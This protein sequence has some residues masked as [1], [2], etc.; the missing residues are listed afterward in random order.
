[1]DLTREVILAGAPGKR[2]PRTHLPRRW[3]AR[4]TTY[5]A[6]RR[7]AALAPITVVAPDPTVRGLSVQALAETFKVK[8]AGVLGVPF[9]VVWLP[10]VSAG[11]TQDEVALLR[12]FAHPERVQVA[13]T[14]DAFDTFVQSLIAKVEVCAERAATGESVD[15]DA[16]RPSPLD[17][18]RAIVAATKDLRVSTG[19]LS[20]PAIATLY[21]VSVSR[22]AKWLGR[23]RQALHKTP[24]ADSVQRQLEFFERIARLRAVLEEPDD[25]RRWLR[26]PNGA[27]GGKRPMDLLDEHRLQV[28]ADL[29]DD[30]LTGSPG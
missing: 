5:A 20:V 23:S 25:F 9:L 8:R 26:M 29:V 4:R 12:L 11:E 21:G 3:K 16:P 30:M 15:A 7:Q 14:Q 24:D 6:L 17:N 10:K 27:F 1:M 19:R 13:R 2:L 18:V 28:V 22:L